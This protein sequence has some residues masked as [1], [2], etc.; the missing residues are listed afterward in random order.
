MAR[1]RTH[2]E[3]LRERLLDTAGEALARGGAAA[4]SLR[5]LAAAVGT[6]TSAVYTLF[7]GKP[8]LLHELYGQ[9]FERL[10][11]GQRAVGVGPDPV[12]DVVAL[13]VAYRETAVADPRAYRMMFGHESTPTRLPAELR[14][15][16]ADAFSPLL[17][18]VHRCVAA[19]RFP[20][21][22]EPAAIATALWANAHGL[23][24]LELG[25]FRPP[26]ATDPAEVFRTATRAV[27][28]GWCALAADQHQHN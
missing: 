28:R 21:A 4:L 18:A 12:E 26:A 20:S 23:V 25:A 13:G 6:S 19:G 9:A 3:K 8:G 7:G 1:P 10:D 16:S 5:S 2:D 24:S 11:A 27:V 17:E 15:R 14:Q 22:P